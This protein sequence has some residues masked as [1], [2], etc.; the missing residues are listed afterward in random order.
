MA[1]HPNGDTVQMGL[2]KADTKGEAAEGKNRGGKVT[3]MKMN[4]EASASSNGKHKVM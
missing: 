2:Q 4:E 1:E 3:T